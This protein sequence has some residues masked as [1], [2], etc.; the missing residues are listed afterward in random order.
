MANKDPE[1]L[2]SPRSPPSLSGFLQL[3]IE[4]PAL[5]P[6]WYP[7]AQGDLH[8]VLGPLLLPRC[9]IDE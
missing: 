8:V 7:E 3:R 5:A 4:A 1:R 2:S 6:Q 9:C